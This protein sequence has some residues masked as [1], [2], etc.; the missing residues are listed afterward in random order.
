MATPKRSTM[1]SPISADWSATGEQKK[2][3]RLVAD[4]Q[5]RKGA[6]RVGGHLDLD[7]ELVRTRPLGALPP[8]YRPPKPARARPQHEGEPARVSGQAS[9]CKIVCCTLLAPEGQRSF[10]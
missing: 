6:S 8:A 1:A 2:C 4:G 3:A 7:Q 5:F 9:A 10:S